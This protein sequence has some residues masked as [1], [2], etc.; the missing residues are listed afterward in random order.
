MSFLV[1][2]CYR[3]WISKSQ[4]V[5][6][7][8]LTDE[9]SWAGCTW[10]TWWLCT[11]IVHSRERYKHK[12]TIKQTQTHKDT[13]T[14]RHRH[15]V[16]NNRAQQTGGWSRVVQRRPICQ[17]RSGETHSSSTFL[18]EAW[19]ILKQEHGLSHLE[20]PKSAEY[21]EVPRSTS[22]GCKS[23]GWVTGEMLQHKHKLLALTDCHRRPP[24]SSGLCSSMTT[25]RTFNSGCLWVTAI[26]TN[27][28]WL[29]GW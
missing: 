26:G 12:D 23:L 7:I 3:S 17:V 4:A 5:L 8:A 29:V 20:V 18:V 10:C 11:T 28:F 15:R 16:Y 19:D 9:K 25:L 1:A 24:P 13:D 6:E 2:F 27:K 14:Q 22:N 21:Q